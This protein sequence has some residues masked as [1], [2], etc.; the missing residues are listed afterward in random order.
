MKKNLYVFA[1][2][3]VVILAIFLL[4]WINREEELIPVVPVLSSYS[5]TTMGFSI[6]VPPDFIIDEGHTYEASPANKISG[7]K[8]TIPK[9]LSEG[10]NLSS[11]TYISVEKKP[12]AINSCSAE[13]YLD[14]SV[15]AGYVDVGSNRYSVAKSNGAGAG[16]RYDETV[17][18]T[19][20]DGGC[21]A[22]RYFI[23][24]TVLENYPEGT[25]T[26]F[27]EIA[28]KN[29]FDSIRVSL[30]LK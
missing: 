21:V 10:T 30:V 1:S 16:N 9:N 25:V 28:V 14:N 13:I 8:F 3:F 26:K 5:S 4:W 6:E 24:S 29:M 20:I 17:Y 18:A 11:N 23:H 15:S 2:V 7:V 22:V 19:P 12:G 27:D